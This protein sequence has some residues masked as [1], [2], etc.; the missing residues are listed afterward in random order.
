[1]VHRGQWVISWARSGCGAN[2]FEQRAGTEAGR[3][4]RCGMWWQLS[5]RMRENA[6]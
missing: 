4:W 2:F 3:D 6:G 1:M 5:R